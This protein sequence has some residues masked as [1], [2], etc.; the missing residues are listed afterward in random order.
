M[1]MRNSVT[2]PIDYY[3]YKFHLLQTNLADL[4]KKKYVNV[5]GITVKC[6][7]LKKISNLIFDL[8]QERNVRKI[9]FLKNG[10]KNQQG[11][12]KSMVSIG[13]QAHAQVTKCCCL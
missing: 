5:I 12:E 9:R 13:T 2:S 11:F 8:I 6:T 7:T 4:T 1:K 3:N 10:T